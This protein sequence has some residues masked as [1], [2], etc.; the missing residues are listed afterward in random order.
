MAEKR[1]KINL[2]LAGVEPMPPGW[3][4]VMK[5]T[6]PCNPLPP[7]F[8]IFFISFCIAKLLCTILSGKWFMHRIIGLNSEDLKP[9]LVRYWYLKFCLVVEN[10]KYSEHDIN[11]WL[12]FQYSNMPDQ[13]YNLFRV[14]CVV[15]FNQDRFNHH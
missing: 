11:T 5:T 14:F 9:G 3:Q 6:I 1:R 7:S 12:F 2:M 8:L 13:L 10:I 15:Y 4:E